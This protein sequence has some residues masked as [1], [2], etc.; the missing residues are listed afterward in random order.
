[1]TSTRRTG[2]LG[3][4]GTKSRQSSAQGRSAGRE[5]AGRSAL[6]H[7]GI[8]LAACGG[9]IAVA[10]GCGRS[11]SNGERAAHDTIAAAPSRALPL[12]LA[13][14]LT[15]GGA[16]VDLATGLLVGSASNDLPP[17]ALVSV[18]DSSVAVISAGRLYPRR[19]GE[20]VVEVRFSECIAEVPLTV[21]ERVASAGALA[22]L[23]EFVRPLSLAPGELSSWRVLPGLYDVEIRSSDSTT[24]GPVFGAYAASCAAFPDGRNHYR[25]QAAE[26]AAL[27]ARGRARK[28]AHDSADTLVI[29]RVDAV[30]GAAHAAVPRDRMCATRLASSGGA[31]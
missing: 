6:S 20:T 30:G 19:R 21:V 5:C 28:R 17:D 11:A 22:P 15:V 25:C 27:V 8:C 3:R 9:L 10:A 4:G 2:R 16:P 26:R 12:A 29:R 7:I 13:I 14:E 18:L 24:H 23:Q 31:N 1:M